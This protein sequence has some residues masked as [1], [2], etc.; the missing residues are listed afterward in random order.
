MTDKSI[1]DRQGGI[2]NIQSSKVQRAVNEDNEAEQEQQ[3]ENEEFE[4]EDDIYMGGE[5]LDANDIQLVLSEPKE[6]VDGD[7]IEV[8]P[9][10][11]IIMS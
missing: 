1:D 9:N 6:E 5:A 4:D 8:I 3:E 2:N 10:G 11:Y 7:Y